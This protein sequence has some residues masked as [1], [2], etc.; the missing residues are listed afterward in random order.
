MFCVPHRAAEKLIWSFLGFVLF[1]FGG[2]GPTSANES[3]D[4]VDVRV[5]I[6]DTYDRIVFD[7]SEPLDY[8]VS[9]GSS[10]GNEQEIVTVSFSKP[11]D[12]NLLNAPE[13]FGERLKG[14][15]LSLSDPSTTIQLW[16]APGMAIAT[17][18]YEE[19]GGYK[20]IVDIVGDQQASRQPA[21]AIVAPKPRQVPKKPIVPKKPADDPPKPK[22]Q[23]PMSPEEAYMAA[24]DAMFADPSD[25]AASFAFVEAA[26][27]MGNVRGAIAGLEQILLVNPNLPNIKMELGILYDRVGADEQA[28]HF[29]AEALES[30]DVPPD[31][32]KRAEPILKRVEAK[33]AAAQNPHK[34][35]ATLFVGGRYETNANAGPGNSNIR[36]FG[37]EGPFLDDEDTEQEDVSALASASLDYAYDFGTQAGHALELGLF[38]FGSRYKDETDVSTS[39]VDG[40]I[41]PRFFL[42]DTLSPW[43]SVRPFATASYLELDDEKY[44]KAYGGG[45]NLRSLLGPAGLNMTLRSVR[46]DFDN[47][48]ERPNASDQT[49]YYSTLRPSVV[50]EPLKGT[51]FGAGAVFG[52]NNADRNFESFIEAGANLFATQYF[53]GGLLTNRPSSATLSTAYR[54]TSY[55]DADIQV[56]PDTERRDNRVDLSLSLDVPFTRSLALSLSGQ[57]TWNGSNLPNNDYDNT[58]VTAGMTYRYGN[59]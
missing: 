36:L 17:N 12:F 51:V 38:G 52:H 30:K 7:S 54:H 16:V 43:G 3:K 46:Q 44:R 15:G 41:G 32:R 49:G 37:F 48:G 10:G 18:S 50:F 57:Q 31:V 11:H 13:D 40:D 21:K 56:D 1:I 47:T 34:V 20:V 5:G 8:N 42:G 55:D 19:D 2:Q 23:A 22:S 27:A 25:P 26:V 9:F 39:L 29:I 35:S 24:F 6:S 59:N 53:A 58:G 14:A 28:E 4:T 33:A 45:L